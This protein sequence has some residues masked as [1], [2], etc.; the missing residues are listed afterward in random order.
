M[1]IFQLYDGR[2]AVGQLRGKFTEAAV[3]L[4]TLA[5]HAV[6][7]LGQRSN[8]GALRFQR[9]RQRVGGVA[10]L[11]GHAAGL[12]ARLGQ[13]A[14]FGIEF[15]PGVLQ[16]GH[17]HDRLFLAAAGLAALLAGA[18]E[19]LR[20]LCQFGFDLLDPPARRVQPALLA[21]QLAGQLGDAAVSHVQRALGILAL[22]LG[23]EQAVAHL[24]QAGLE[25]L[26]ARLQGLD[27]VA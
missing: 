24:G 22:L 2:V 13:A 3:E 16:L 23:G 27:L 12:V 15:L 8:L 4:A 26:F 19:R 10:R 17:P 14:A 11:A 18:I 1:A 25:F 21:L 6:E 7:R 9:Q 20:Q 5:A